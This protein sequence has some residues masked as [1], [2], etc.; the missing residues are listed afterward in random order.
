MSIHQPPA[1]LGDLI[2]GA[3]EQAGLD[4]T[5][6]AQRAGITPAYLA[7]LE[8][9]DKAPGR[10]TIARLGRALPLPPEALAALYANEQARRYAHPWHGKR[11]MLGYRRRAA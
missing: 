8:R 11:R 7:T 5:A 4:R 2:R 9:A 6:A 10:D 3:R 1:R